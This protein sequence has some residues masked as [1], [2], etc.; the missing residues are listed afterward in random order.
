MNFKI[1]GKSADEKYWQVLL[2]VDIVPAGTGWIAADKLYTRNVEQVAVVAAPPLLPQMGLSVAA[3]TPL[4]A[5]QV[6]I[7]LR[8]GP[9]F[10]YP[11]IGY[12]LRGQ[13]FPV[14]GQSENGL[15]LRLRVPFPISADGSAWVYGANLHSLAGGYVPV[16]GK[17]QP[18]WISGE[19]AGPA[20]P[21]LANSTLIKN[22]FR[23]SEFFTA[24][25]EVLNNTAGTWSKGDIDVAYLAALNNRAFH[26]SPNRTDL[27]GH[28]AVGQTVKVVVDGQA[29]DIPGFY[30]EVWALANGS[31]SVCLI[32]V[33]I[34]VVNPQ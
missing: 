5:A 13:V 11:V 28:I 20:C 24:E 16:I 22:T 1:L 8:F 19:Q 2:P 4:S 33:D 34:W 7:N 6:T 3:G 31:K 25:F 23:P 26:V 27:P 30:R 12:A 9:G 17:P 10:E 15:W 21:L 29:W 18:P 14:T 32:F